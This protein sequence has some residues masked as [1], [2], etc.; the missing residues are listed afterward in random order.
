MEML[1]HSY[2]NQN[3]FIMNLQNKRLMVDLKKL[4][5]EV[6]YEYVLTGVIALSTEQKYIADGYANCHK[7]TKAIL[8]AAGYEVDQLNKL[9][10]NINDCL[11]SKR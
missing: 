5:Q 1:R 4:Q 10:D 9:D 11:N 8:V 7:R 6:E 2:T 3:T